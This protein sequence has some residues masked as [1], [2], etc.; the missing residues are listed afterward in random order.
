MIWTLV[1]KELLNNLLTLR[2]V[3]ALSLAV[4]LSVLTA[5][6]GSLDFTK[7]TDMYRTE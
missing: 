1:R 7:A 4:I 5:V 3:V 2:L 6:V